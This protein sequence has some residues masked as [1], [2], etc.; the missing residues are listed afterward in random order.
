[1]V[2]LTVLFVSVSVQEWVCHQW[3]FQVALFCVLGKCSYGLVESIGILLM[4]T[5]ALAL[6]EQADKKPRLGWVRRSI[7]LEIIVL[8]FCYKVSAKMSS[9]IRAK[10]W[11]P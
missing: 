2:D 11:R 4:S 3:M 10:C 1:M 7:I 9:A 6:A 8:H 5:C